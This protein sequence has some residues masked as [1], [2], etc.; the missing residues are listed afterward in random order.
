MKGMWRRDHRHLA[1]AAQLGGRLAPP[2]RLGPRQQRRHRVRLRV[3][4][5][6]RA[7]PGSQRLQ[8]D[9]ATATADT[10]PRTRESV[11]DLTTGRR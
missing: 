1:S 11:A 10:V 4:L 5:R 3:G 9:P 8:L 7:A 2:T 6:S